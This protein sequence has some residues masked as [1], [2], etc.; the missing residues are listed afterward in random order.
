MKN[1][2][3]SFLIIFIIFVGLSGCNEDGIDLTDIGD[4]EANPNN[5]IGKEVII[6]GNCMYGVVKDDLG[7]SI[8]YGYH[9]NLVGE[10]RLTGIIRISET[11]SSVIIEVYKVEAI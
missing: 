6:E 3:L 2:Y 11:F 1:R 4:I 7:H 10:Y 9:Q 8:S 5:Y